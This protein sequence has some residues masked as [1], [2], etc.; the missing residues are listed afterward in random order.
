MANGR[1]TSRT[2]KVGLLVA[3]S[4]LT[5]MTFLF[6]IGSEEKTFS[7]KNHYVVLLE[8]AAGLAEGNPVQMAGVNVGSVQD[9]Q[10]PKD[11][12]KRSVTITIAIQKKYSERVRTDS[13]AKLRKLGL[14][15]A[16][17]YIDVSLGSPT[18]PRLPPG[19]IIPS[20]K[21]TNVDQLLA[22][23]GDLVDNFAQ[24]SVSL[25]NI[26]SR[27]DRGEGLLGELT[28]QPATKQ[29]LTD[30]LLA[31][32]NKTNNLLDHVR[33]GHGLVGKLIYD[34]NY[35]AQLTGSLQTSAASLQSIM[36]N[37]QHGIESGEGMVPALLTDPRGKKNVIALVENLRVT[38]ENV[39]ALTNS[40]KT[41]EGIVPRLMSDKEYADQTLDEFRLLVRRLNETARKL[42]EGEGTAG[43]LIADPSVYESINDILIGINESKLLRW[44]IRNRQSKGIETRYKAATGSKPVATDDSKKDAKPVA[45]PDQ[46][47]VVA[48]PPVANPPATSTSPAEPTSTAPATDTAT[49]PPPTDTAPPSTDTTG[50]TTTTTTSPPAP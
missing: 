33:G 13:R 46:P 27:V 41:G 7:K 23:G 22:S 28:T 26:L 49:P 14:I 29:R 16:D 47:P 8:S 40:M 24:I 50:S 25:R 9:I 20:A 31:T 38:S 44:I 4:L 30:T 34:D 17:S 6:F 36:Q 3:I 18:E 12:K 5:L 19:S 48:P 2:F 15:A 43:R 10:L 11:P 42:N 35:S 32:L 21:A 39:A 1:D 37:L 45:P